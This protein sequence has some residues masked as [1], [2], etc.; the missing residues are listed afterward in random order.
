MVKAAKGVSIICVFND[1]EK[2]DR[3]LIPNLKIQKA[4]YELIAIDNRQNDFTCAASVL[5]AAAGKAKYDNLMFVHQDVA[6]GSYTW[7]CDTLKDL[8][9]LDEFG[10]AGAAG[11]NAGG[12]VGNVTYGNPPRKLACPAIEAPVP[13][14]T[15]DGCLL[16]VQREFFLKIGFD[17]ITCPGWYLYVAN[18]C[19]DAARL[20]RKVY[21]LPHAIYHESIGLGKRRFYQKTWKNII[22]R[23][24]GNFDSIYLTVGDWKKDITTGA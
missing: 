4:E 7:L 14:Q 13:V 11:K 19:L 1:Q 20:G 6:L 9:Q 15:L 16:T 24:R 5:N 12:L 3:L 10:G 17:E 23:H 22:A 2:L 8:A 21:V 18:Y